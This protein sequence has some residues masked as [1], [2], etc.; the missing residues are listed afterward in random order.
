MTTITQMIA[1][2]ESFT[3][4][5]VL[6][7]KD[8]ADF[9]DYLD[10]E[11]YF[12]DNLNDLAWNL[13]KGRCYSLEECDYEDTR[14]FK[15]EEND[16]YF[17]MF[18]PKN[19]VHFPEIKTRPFK[20]MK[21]FMEDT[22]LKVG[23]AIY[24]RNKIPSD[25]DYVIRLIT[26]LNNDAVILGHTP[27]YFNTLFDLQMYSIDGHTWKG[28]VHTEQEVQEVTEVPTPK[29]PLVTREYLEKFMLKEDDTVDEYVGTKGWFFNRWFFNADDMDILM[30]VIN[31]GGREEN[32]G[33][34]DLF[35]DCIHGDGIHGDLKYHQKDVGWF[36]CFIPDPKDA[37]RIQNILHKRKK[38]QD[39]IFNNDDVNGPHTQSEYLKVLQYVNQEGYFGINEDDVL[40]KIKTGKTLVLGKVNCGDLCPYDAKE[41]G[42][43]G[44]EYSGSYTHFIPK[45]VVDDILGE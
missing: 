34:H 43:D 23:D 15:P 37:Y 44:A 40:R 25:A 21:E 1:Q 38:L 5:D 28:F 30:E 42:R 11:G 14:C 31:D 19:K 18:L 8:R 35:G 13:H 7:W 12:A 22:G 10:T 6:T 24:L 4:A 36:K 32:Y 26:G 2:K 29:I 45:S 33:L 27:L 41:L 39:S 9:N 16:K 3:I 17:S 20:S